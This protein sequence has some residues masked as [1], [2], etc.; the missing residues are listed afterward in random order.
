MTLNEL[1]TACG[2]KDNLCRVLRV[3]ENLVLELVDPKRRTSKAE[4][5]PFNS[6]LSQLTWQPETPPTETRWRYLGELIDDSGC[7]QPT[8][9][10]GPQSCVT[11]GRRSDP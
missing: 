1:I 10:A 9:Y 5:L 6:S 3:N 7:R 4:S 11:A 8:Y 2:G